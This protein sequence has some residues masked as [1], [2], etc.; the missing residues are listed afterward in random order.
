MDAEDSA[1]CS[2]C[3]IAQGRSEAEVVFE[4][5]ENVAFLP[6][7]P[8]TL[9]HTLVVPRKHVRD[10]WD[11]ESGSAKSLMES[12]LRVAHGLRIALKPQGLNLINSSGSAATQTVFHL[13]MHLVPRWDGD[14]VGDIWPPKRPLADAAREQLA[15]EVREGVEVAVRLN[16]PS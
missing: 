2:F 16:L 7:N 8:A 5:S 4:S 14:R 13:H 10:L 11:L 9:G 15:S 6:L 12:T 1:E 3:L